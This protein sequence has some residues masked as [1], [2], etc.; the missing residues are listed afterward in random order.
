MLIIAASIIAGGLA[1]WLLYYVLFYDLEDFLGGFG[2]FLKKLMHRRRRHTIFQRTDL[3]PAN[4]ADF[5]EESWSSGI[6]F[7][8]FLALS[9]WAGYLTYSGLHKLF[10]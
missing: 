9:I 5:E 7:L 8:I 1:A 2:K 3:T 4:P 6:R 10:G